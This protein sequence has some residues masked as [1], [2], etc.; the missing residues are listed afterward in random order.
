MR[1]HRNELSELNQLEW[2][3]KEC[4]GRIFNL[5]P[6]NQISEQ[7]EEAGRIVECIF[8][9]CKQKKLKRKCAFDAT[10]NE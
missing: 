10:L 7:G 5:I 3:G 1:S 2:G 6:S 4:R 9:Q 8:E